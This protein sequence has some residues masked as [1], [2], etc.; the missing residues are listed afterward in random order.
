M[1]EKEIVIDMRA[2]IDD[3]KEKLNS[4]KRV[5]LKGQGV[6]M[7]PFITENDTLILNKPPRKVKTG[8]I[9]LYRRLS[10]SYAIHRVYAVRKDYVLMLGDA[11]LFIEKVQKDCLF[12]MVSTVE[13]PNK[14]VNCNSFSV[15]LG[16]VFRMKKKIYKVK[17]KAEIRQIYIKILG[18]LSKIKRLIIRKDK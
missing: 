1:T 2:L 15:R 10:G 5:I 16:C 11:Q 9:Y 8:E 17:F 12:A 3:L 7:F 4:N 13:K 6:S 18:F 14:S